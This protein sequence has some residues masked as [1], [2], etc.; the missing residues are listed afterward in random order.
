VC[1]CVYVSVC[2]VGEREGMCVG[3]ERESEREIESVCVRACVCVCVK[4]KVKVKLLF[5][6]GTL[7]KQ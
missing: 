2:R 7:N 4:V 5:S 6:D 3:C 1:V